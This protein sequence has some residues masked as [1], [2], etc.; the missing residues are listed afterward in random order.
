VLKDIIAVQP[1]E[2]YQLHLRFEDDIEGIVDISQLI[3]FRGIFAPLQDPAYFATVTV[4]PEIG[5]LV[6]DCGADLD[7]DVLYAIASQQ[8]IPAYGAVATTH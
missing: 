6:W 2:N 7:P 8:P 5:T 1:L 4:N 3:E